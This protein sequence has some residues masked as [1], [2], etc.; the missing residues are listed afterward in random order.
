MNNKIAF[1]CRNFT[2]NCQIDKTYP[3]ERVVYITSSNIKYR[4]VIKI[5]YN[6]ILLDVFPD[7]DPDVRKEEQMI[8]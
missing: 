8:N 4:N 5:L 3:R 2:W 1:Y 7:F 6:S